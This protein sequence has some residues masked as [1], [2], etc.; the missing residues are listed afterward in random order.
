MTSRQSN[1]SSK[2]TRLDLRDL[3]MSIASTHDL[4]FD[5]VVAADEVAKD[6][7][8]FLTAICASADLDMLVRGYRDGPAVRV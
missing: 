5:T 7:E 4:L 6:D 3:A 8:E 1:V 2:S